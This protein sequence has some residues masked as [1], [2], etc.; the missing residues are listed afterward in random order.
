MGQLV[1]IKTIC[2]KLRVGR[3]TLDALRKRADFPLPALSVG[4]LK[5]WSEQEIDEWLQNSK[6]E[7]PKAA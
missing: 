7:T 6:K 1:D 2:A 5:R 3:T 4:K